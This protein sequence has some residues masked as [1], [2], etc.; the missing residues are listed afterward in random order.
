MGFSTLLC[1]IAC[2]TAEQSNCEEPFCLYNFLFNHIYNVPQSA[3]AC[4]SKQRETHN[5]DSEQQV[6]LAQLSDF[7][8]TGSHI[9]CHAASA[10]FTGHSRSPIIDISK[11]RSYFAGSTFFNF[12]VVTAVVSASTS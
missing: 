4:L 2:R 11:K 10:P 1:G 6:P 3:H 7:M 12:D 8:M 5:F 9:P